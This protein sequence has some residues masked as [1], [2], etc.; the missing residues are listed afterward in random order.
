MKKIG[1]LGLMAAAGA[2]GLMTYSLMNKSTSRNANKLVNDMLSKTDQFV[3][4]K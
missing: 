2:I 3:K 4:G 1:Y